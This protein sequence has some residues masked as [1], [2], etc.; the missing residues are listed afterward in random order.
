MQLLG[1]L[2]Y[3][4]YLTQTKP[5]GS[6][7]GFIDLLDYMRVVGYGDGFVFSSESSI[8]LI[9]KLIGFSDFTKK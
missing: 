6:S 8:F 3:P 5:Y 1:S 4:F 2:K 7:F 9:T